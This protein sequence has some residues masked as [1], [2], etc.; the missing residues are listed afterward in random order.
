MAYVGVNSLQ[1]IQAVRYFAWSNSTAW[2]EDRE[3]KESKQDVE[4]ERYIFRDPVFNW[5]CQW[6]LTL[7]KT[8]RLDGLGPGTCSV[9]VGFR[10]SGRH[11]PL[12]RTLRSSL[13]KC[14]CPYTELW[15]SGSS[16][17]VQ[18]VRRSREEQRRKSWRNAE[19]VDVVSRHPFYRDP[20]HAHRIP[21]QHLCLLGCSCPHSL[22]SELL[23]AGYGGMWREKRVIWKYQLLWEL[24]IFFLYKEKGFPRNV[25]N[26]ENIFRSSHKVIFG[27]K[28]AHSE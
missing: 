28:H 16:T 18:R 7:G 14:L 23:L 5:Q 3:A 13:G 15:N 8:C 6:L 22:L 25:L 11:Q 17:K 10:T 4:I 2:L 20:P 12:L 24:W 27:M 26:L 1:G 19:E 9:P 21:L